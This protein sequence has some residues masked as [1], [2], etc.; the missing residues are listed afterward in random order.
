MFVLIKNEKYFYA[1][2]CDYFKGFDIKQVFRFSRMMI[3][4]L[5]QDIKLM[6]D[7]ALSLPQRYLKEDIWQKRRNIS[8]FD[9]EIIVREVVKNYS[10]LN[11]LNKTIKNENFLLL[12]IRY[13]R[14]FEGVL[15][16]KYGPHDSIL[17]MNRLAHRQFIWQAENVNKM[18]MYRYYRVYSSNKSLDDIVFKKT[19]LTVKQMYQLG[20]GLIG[21]YYDFDSMKR[22][23]KME[24]LGLSEENMENFISTF[25]MDISWLSDYARENDILDNKFLYGFNV[26]REY[27]LI[28]IEDQIFC[29]VPTY[30]FWRITNGIFYLIHDVEGFGDKYGK[31]FED[32]LFDYFEKIKIT[33]EW[34]V[35]RE[36]EYKVGKDRKDGLDFTLQNGP[37]TLFVE[38]K[39]RRMSMISK[40]ASIL[41]ELDDSLDNMVDDIVKAYKNVFDCINGNNPYYDFS[42]NQSLFLA[43]I[44]L[45]EWFVFGEVKL[46][47]ISKVRD[48]LKAEGLDEHIL[49][50]CPL[51]VC[52]IKDFESAIHVARKVGLKKFL[53]TA[54]SKEHND[55][56]L[57]S[58]IR[59]EFSSEE[60]TFVF[61]FE[62][63][64]DEM[65]SYVKN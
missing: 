38:C 5:Q 22:L 45:E 46:R 26:L 29:P 51:L 56:L 24:I 61:P 25:S 57:A 21:F 14:D 20:M 53:S 34:S 7:I 2:L 11:N 49:E 54:A 18:M 8:E 28:I 42:A 23:P 16:D 43:F 17:L 9:I 59:K 35:F 62:S 39:A 10:L 15:I 48:R 4:H 63:E 52:S 19:N 41:G 27:P 12:T 47:L 31:S 55:L 58:L 30:I 33:S 40:S 36:K 64:L 37:V 1:L 3:N 50:T 13:L 44:T 65:F 60:T 32:Y 6:P